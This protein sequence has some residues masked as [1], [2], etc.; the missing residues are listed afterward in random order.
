MTAWIDNHACSIGLVLG[1]VI[2][3]LILW[4][5][6]PW[7]EWGFAMALLFSAFSYHPS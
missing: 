7:I 4:A 3:A 6:R 5:L 2:M 1:V